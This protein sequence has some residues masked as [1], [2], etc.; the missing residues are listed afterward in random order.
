MEASGSSVMWE[1]RL[2]DLAAR[3]ESDTIPCMELQKPLLAQLAH[4][5]GSWTGVNTQTDFVG[6]G[7]VKV[8]YTR[9]ASKLP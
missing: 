1:Q 3:A 5:I 4:Q 6:K 9:P 7:E 2:R 8:T